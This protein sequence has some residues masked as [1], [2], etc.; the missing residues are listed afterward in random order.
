MAESNLRAPAALGTGEPAGSPAGGNYGW[1]E[2]VQR[3][4][5]AYN[6]TLVSTVPIYLPYAA[7][8]AWPAGGLHYA[9]ISE[10]WVDIIT[11]FNSATSA[12][13]TVGKTAGTFEYAGSASTIDVKGATARVTPTLTV[14]QLTNMQKVLQNTIYA[15][16]TSVGQPSAGS[17]IVTVRYAI[18][19]SQNPYVTS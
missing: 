17:V 16:V 8:L 10:I 11:A 15:T 6:A 5:V 19:T 4:T 18:C 2:C 14:T 1:V 12:Y 9:M 3:A 13:L 7:G